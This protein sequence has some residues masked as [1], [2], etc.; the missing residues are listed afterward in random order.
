MVRTSN[1]S[2]LIDNM[3]KARDFW[4]SLS[5]NGKSIKNTIP[6]TLTIHPCRNLCELS[7]LLVD[8][9]WEYTLIPLLLRLP[10]S[11]QRHVSSIPSPDHTSR[12][13]IMKLIGKL[14][15]I[16]I[17]QTFTSITNRSALKSI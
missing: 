11:Q 16:A 2:S 13:Y 12:Y 17:I 14:G 6:F 7:L 9:I 1:V 3:G 15:S 5:S 8:N 10:P 4:Q